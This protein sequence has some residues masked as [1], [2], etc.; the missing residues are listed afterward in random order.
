M[1]GT[2]QPKDLAKFYESVFQKAPDMVDGEEW[3]GW[4]VGSVFFGIGQH[5]EM[6]V[7]AKEPGRVMF[8]LE[9]PEVQAEF[10][11]IKDITGAKVVKGPYDMNGMMIA[12]LEDPDGNYFQ[13]MSPWNSAE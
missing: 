3:F 5:S 1:V 9:T 13:L 2:T 6:N 7:Q 10:D 4:Q 11:R 8:N 12:T